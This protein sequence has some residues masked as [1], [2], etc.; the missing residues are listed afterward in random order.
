VVNCA[1]CGTVLDISTITYITR[2]REGEKDG[3]KYSFETT[4]PTCG[5]CGAQTV[6]YDSKAGK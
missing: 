3:R 4:S 6:S 5:H 1:K 2:K